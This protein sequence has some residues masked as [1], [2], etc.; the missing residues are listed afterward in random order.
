M[1]QVWVLV[2]VACGGGGA[3]PDAGTFDAADATLDAP[4]APTDAARDADEDSA[5]DRLCGCLRGAEGS[6]T[7]TLDTTGALPDVLTELSG[8][9]TSR[10]DDT[11]FWA[12]DDSGG[13][14]ALYAIG[15]DG[16]LR[17]TLPL[18][19][20]NRDW[21]ELAR[22]P[23]DDTDLDRSCL[24]VGD[25]G[26]NDSVY[27][28]VRVHRVREPDP[29]EPIRD[30][31]VVESMELTFPDGARDTE[32]FVV[33]DDGTLVL[34]TKRPPIGHFRVYTARFVPGTTATSIFHDEIALGP[35]NRASMFTAADFLAESAGSAADF[36]PSCEVLLGRHYLGAFVTFAS[37][38]T[39]LDEEALHP[40]PV[41]RER[42][43]EAIGFT[44]DGYRHVGEG[45]RA[46]IHR[47][48]CVSR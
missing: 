7:L 11:I 29:R 37:D 22:G 1:R 2:V 38:L 35:A 10:F 31:A 45:S 46:P 25:V 3:T 44:A 15:D 21:E 9:V 30:E 40:V 43:G 16:S 28:S 32:A 48:R 17:A 20:D 47:W 4:V 36:A 26:D 19:V 39:R 24:Y 5:V 41:E 27:P 23:C 8:L 18:P 6:Y 34:L 13:E 12:H 42:Q 14:A 33:D